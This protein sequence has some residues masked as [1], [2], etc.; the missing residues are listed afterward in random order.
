MSNLSPDE[1][2]YFDMVEADELQALLNE[3][4]GIILARVGAHP[5]WPARVCEMEEWIDYLPHRQRKGQLCVYFY[6]SHNYG[7]ILRSNVHEFMEEH[8]SIKGK[9]GS[10]IYLQYLEGVEEAKTAIA[11]A[12]KAHESM[13]F[14]ERI[15]LKK[16]EVENDVPCAVCK[17]KGSYERR[18]VCD[19]KDCEREYHMTCL[20]PPLVEVPAGDWFCP[21]CNLS[22]QPSSKRTPTNGSSNAKRRLASSIHAAEVAPLPST[23]SSTATPLSSRRDRKTPDTSKRRECREKDRQTP[24]SDLTSEER[25]FLCGLGG[26]LVVCEFSKC[27]KVYHQLCLGAF[28]FPTD[29]ETEWICPRHRC[30]L[31]GRKEDPTSSTKS[32]WHCLHCP[33]AIDDSVLPSSPALSKISRRD[34]TMVCA[35]CNSPSPMVRLAKI[36]ERIWSVIATNRQG[37]PF[38]GPLLVGIDRPPDMD[39]HALPLDLFQIIA[40]VRSLRYSSEV[41]FVQDVETVVATSLAILRD[42]SAP[43]VEAAKTMSMVVNEQLQYH[44]AQF[45]TIQTLMENYLHADK[46]NDE[47][48]SWSIPWRKECM[49]FGDKSYVHIEARSIEEWTSY[50]SH[51]TLYANLSPMASQQHED[52]EERYTRYGTASP[53][54]IPLTDESKTTEAE[55]DQRSLTLTDGIDVLV[56][57]SDLG[58]HHR[59]RAS[60]IPSTAASAPEPSIYREELGLTP[61]ICEMDAMFQQQAALLRKALH[62]HATLEH[63]WNLNKQHMLGMRQDQVISIGEGR[64]AAELRV[65][66]NNLKARLRNKDQVLQQLTSDH[67]DLNGQV[68]QLQTALDE[69][70]RRLR[71]L[72]GQLDPSKR[73]SFTNAKVSPGSGD[74]GDDDSRSPL[75]KRA[76][77]DDDSPAI[78]RGRGRPPKRRPTYQ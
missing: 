35:H 31:S 41:A 52:A 69:K 78:K 72:E 25:C 24:T 38:C 19:G 18:I 32:L 15:K 37:T 65:A 16:I 67:F 13:L 23:D 62:A 57:L 53:P 56:A 74:E 76:R 10:K 54:R 17:K 3:H 5:F 36:L 44:Q 64:L 30:V 50:V 55:A 34:K 12:K 21:L 58:Q 49:P 61:S 70:E 43:L 28:P 77:V 48:S 8:P 33:V 26:E 4:W 6:G 22:R 9:K 66:N 42:R 11:M 14:S 75:E 7:W 20:K 40:A 39:P 71:L 27:T 63:A 2:E 45:Q 29:E 47:L 59:F 1:A 51:A 46:K 73:N 68:K 60:T